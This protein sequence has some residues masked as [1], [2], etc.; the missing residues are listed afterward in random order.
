MPGATLRSAASSGRRSRSAIVLDEAAHVLEFEVEFTQGEGLFTAYLDSTPLHTIDQR[1]VGAGKHEVLLALNDVG[2]GS[3]TISFRL[4]S[5]TDRPAE[6]LLT[7]PTLGSIVPSPPGDFSQN[8]VLDAADIDLL[9][10][11]I[12]NGDLE[13]DLNSNGIV[14][15]P[16]RVVWVHDVKNTFFGD[17]NL[18]G[19]FNSADLVLVFQGAQYEDD[20]AG[21]ST[22]V[23]GDWD[24]N[25]ELDTADLV[26]AFQQGVFEMG[27]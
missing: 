27:P 14:D 21:N 8:A 4:D 16:D 9:T 13:Y 22:W 18:N 7:N 1:Q 15:A 10:L 5:V 12:G 3:H 2:P 24:G 19:E 25:R 6:V 23:T 11:A 20:V 26:L 17:A